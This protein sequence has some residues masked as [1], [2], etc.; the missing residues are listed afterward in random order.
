[1]IRPQTLFTSCLGFLWDPSGPGAPAPHHGCQLPEAPGWQATSRKRLAPSPWLNK[2]VDVNPLGFSPCLGPML[3]IEYL[4]WR[5]LE[6]EGLTSSPSPTHGRWVRVGWSQI[7]TELR[8]WQMQ[9]EC[10]PGKNLKHLLQSYLQC[11]SRWP[12][13]LVCK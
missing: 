9:D 6:P 12:G 5:A 7:N 13:F 1:M 2:R 4:E 11:F 10:R 3:L 8:D